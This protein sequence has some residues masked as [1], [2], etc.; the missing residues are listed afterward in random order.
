M[1]IKKAFSD[2]IIQCKGKNFSIKHGNSISLEFECSPFPMDGN[3]FQLIIQTWNPYPN[4][5][6]TSIHSP[7]R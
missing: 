2:A 5:V 4:T 1:V 3:K 6:E 7:E